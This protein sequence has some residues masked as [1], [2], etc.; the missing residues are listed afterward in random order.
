M[1]NEKMIF[2]VTKIVV[3]MS[4]RTGPQHGQDGAS[5]KLNEAPKRK[6]VKIVHFP[7]LCVWCIHLDEGFNFGINPRR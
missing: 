5:K 7:D 6:D 2:F 3:A 4:K 1:S